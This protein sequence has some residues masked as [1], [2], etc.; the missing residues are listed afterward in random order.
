MGCMWGAGAAP[1]QRAWGRR[2]GRGIARVVAGERILRARKYNLH[3]AARGRL[4]GPG[5]PLCK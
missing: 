2:G 1:T 3:A 4:S 5:G